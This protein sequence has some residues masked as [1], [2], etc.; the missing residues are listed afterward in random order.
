MG[1]GG[2]EE[3]ERRRKS[4]KEGRKEGETETLGRGQGPRGSSELRCPGKLPSPEQVPLLQMS[5]GL[6]LG[7]DQLDSPP[8]PSF[9]L[10][11]L[12]LFFC[13][14]SPFPIPFLKNLQETKVHD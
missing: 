2:R 14:V 13:V 7:H 4:W 11:S 1:K 6:G 5:K 8:L 3:V 10:S 9:L 12:P